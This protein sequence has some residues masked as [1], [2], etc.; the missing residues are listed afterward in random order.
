MPPFPDLTW[1][2]TK[3]PFS[4]HTHICITLYNMISVLSWE[5]PKVKK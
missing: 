4:S 2:P 5:L 1:T 3:F